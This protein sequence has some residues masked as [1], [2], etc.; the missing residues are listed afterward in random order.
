MRSS[1]DSSLKDSRL[2]TVG[3]GPNPL[4]KV[5]RILST[6]GLP[7]LYP[8]GLPSL[9]RYG[10]RL[11]RV[12]VRTGSDRRSGHWLSEDSRA[13]IGCRGSSLKRL[14]GEVGGALGSPAALAGEWGLAALIPWRRGWLSGICGRRSFLERLSVASE[15]AL[16][17]GVLGLG[18]TAAGLGLQ[19]A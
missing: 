13:A 9:L 7:S 11:F 3:S 16:S 19:H 18:T 12:L 10:S 17:L 4:L 6:S 8:L 2:R 14:L 15:S 5:T 1:G